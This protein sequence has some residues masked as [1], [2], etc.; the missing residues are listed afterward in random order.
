MSTNR[1]EAS[2]LK[3]SWAWAPVV[4][5]AV[6]ALLG[7]ILASGGVYLAMLGGSLY[8]AIVGVTLL[9]AGYLMMRRRIAGFYVYVGAFVFTVLWTIWEVGLTG[10][11]L[12]PRLV[13]PFILLVLAVLVVPL[14]D[15][16]GGRRV[17]TI[18][19]ADSK[20]AWYQNR[21]RGAGAR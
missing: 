4:L 10:W 18:G 19:I 5:G 2:A 3:A 6:I 9:A 21:P 12:I 7:V 20:D 1:H 8:Y 16:V 15:A 14:L 17:R 13:G 11:P